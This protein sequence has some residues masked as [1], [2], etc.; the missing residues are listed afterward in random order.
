MN[1][2]KDNDARQ[3]AD[4]SGR[5]GRFAAELRAS[6]PEAALTQPDTPTLA[7]PTHVPSILEH[8]QRRRQ[9]QQDTAEKLRAQEFVTGA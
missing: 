3:A 6:R 2:L 9:R 4:W 1:S 8:L 5:L 7:S